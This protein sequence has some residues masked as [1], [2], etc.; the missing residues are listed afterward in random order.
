MTAHFKQDPTTGELHF[1]SYSPFP[2]HL[3]YYIAS[4]KGHNTCSRMVDGS[5]PRLMHDFAITATK[6]VVLDLPVV[7]DSENASGIP[8]RWWWIGARPPDRPG[9]RGDR[10]PVNAGPC[11]GD[12]DRT[13]T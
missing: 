7:F 1:F 8:N 10:D 6:A 13:A 2:P 12:R 11:N 5:G 3:T 4:P 9:Q